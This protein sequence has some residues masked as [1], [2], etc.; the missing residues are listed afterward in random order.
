MAALPQRDAAEQALG[1]EWQALPE[2]AVLPDWQS[3]LRYGVYT[4]DFLLFPSVPRHIGHMVP[5]AKAILAPLFR[6]SLQALRTEN[7]FNAARWIGSL[8]HYIED[9]GSPPHAAGI[10]GGP[11]HS[12]MEGWFD[13]KR[14]EI[15]GYEP[16]LLGR[17][18]DEAVRGFEAR[19]E[20]LIAYS[21]DRGLR[22]A[23]RLEA[24]E[25]REDQELI[26]ESAL[27]VARA[28]AD[29]LH[30]LFRLGLAPIEPSGCE[31]RGRVTIAGHDALPPGR[32]RVMLAGTELSTVTDLAGHYSFRHLPPG[33]VTPLVQATGAET[34]RVE[35]IE[36]RPDRPAQR[37]IA[38][39]PDRFGANVI[40]NAR[41]DLSWYGRDVPDGWRRDER[42]A[43]RWASLP[44]PVAAGTRLRLFVEYTG[45][46]APVAIRWRRNALDAGS[47]SVTAVS[48]A[49]MDGSLLTAIVEAE[50]SSDSGYGGFVFAEVLIETERPLREVCRHLALVP[51]SAASPR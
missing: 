51:V 15:D 12:A 7:A 40:R 20:R 34:G 14:I 43:K 2:Y 16:V 27:E 26:L 6:R 10:G 25:R 11:L 23:P 21:R 30:T 19:I 5:E 38:L 8:L 35:S 32:A 13:A 39:A 1:G 42:D 50:S 44:V 3:T 46:P 37:D 36:L 24:L 31:L 29:A 45:A 22:L 28:V 17:T 18:D 48:S 41:L 9:C 33:R 47:G 49:D 4:D